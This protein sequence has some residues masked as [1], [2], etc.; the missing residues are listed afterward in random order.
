[1][2]A[3]HR[4]LKE[5]LK[6]LVRSTIFWTMAMLLFSVF[7]YYALKNEIGI[8]IDDNYKDFYQLKDSLFNFAFGGFLIGVLYTT[9]EFLI[10]KFFAKNNSLVFVILLEIALTFIGIIIVSSLVLS[11]W[12]KNKNIPY[13]VEFGWWYKDNSFIPALIYIGM[14]II[15][16]SLITIVFEKFGKGVFFKMLIGSYKKP[17]ETKRV[18]MFLDLKS[19]TTIAER[20]G[21]HQYSQF[22]QDFFYDLNEIVASYEAEIYQYIG[23]EAVLNWSYKK[24]V[25]KNNCLNLFYAFKKKIQSKSKFYLEKYEVIPE[26]KVGIHGGTLMVA[27]VGVVKK[28]LAYHGDVINTT[29]RVQAK[30]SEY[31]V[32]ILITKNLLNDLD[33][34]DYFEDAL[35]AK[36]ILKGKEKPVELY[37]LREIEL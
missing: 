34:E 20:L 27:E 30:C 8:S 28:E 17:K 26:F 7:R 33:I 24:G 22:I 3:T 37:T 10:D 2:E 25:Y 9:I 21:H 11:W 4:N 18:F 12:V 5:Y 6:R 35:V 19:S 31:C 29:A 13:V 14:S 1:M 36:T 23:D 32:S 16:Y 15:I